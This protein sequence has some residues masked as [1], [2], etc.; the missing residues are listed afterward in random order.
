MIPALVISEDG[1]TYQCFTPT[2]SV[3]PLFDKEEEEEKGSLR[4]KFTLSWMKP[5]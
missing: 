3:V 4:K 2:F 1:A 5:F